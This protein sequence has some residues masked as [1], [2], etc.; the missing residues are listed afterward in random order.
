MSFIRTGV[1]VAA[2]GLL[3]A[4]A[5]AAPY[6]KKGD[7]KPAE[8]EPPYGQPAAPYPQQAPLGDAEPAPKPAYAP[9]GAAAGYRP[10]LPPKP[11][12]QTGGSRLATRWMTRLQPFFESRLEPGVGGAGE[13]HGGEQE[14]GAE[15]RAYTERMITVINP[16]GEPL[17]VRV[18]CYGAGGDLVFQ[19]MV[20]L[21]PAQA[22]SDVTR[23]A[24]DTRTA[25]T[26]AS[27][28][29]RWCDL[30]SDMPFLAYQVTRRRA[31]MQANLRRPKLAGGTEVY[32]THQDL[33][34]ETYQD[35]IAVD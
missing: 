21:E 20:R 6:D 4:A 31:L 27:R 14:E 7:A 23:D 1:A 28:P 25:N 8:P 35:L 3:A 24:T 19:Q 34:T 22:A 9:K 10:P 30:M 11:V 13:L 18:S 5:Q 29:A 2:L 16:Q 17:T 12:Y 15:T 32:R 33:T 26:L